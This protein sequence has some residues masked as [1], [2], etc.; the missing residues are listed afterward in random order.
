MFIDSTAA[1]GNKNIQPIFP[2]PFRLPT[3]M[4]QICVKLVLLTSASPDDIDSCIFFLFSSLLFHCFSLGCGAFATAF[5]IFRN[6]PPRAIYSLSPCLPLFCFHFYCV[7]VYVSG[8]DKVNIYF[9]WYIKRRTIYIVFVLEWGMLGS[10]GVFCISSWPILYIE[11]ESKRANIMP[12]P[13][14]HTHSPESF[15]RSG[16]SYHAIHIYFWISSSRFH[17]FYIYNGVFFL[18]LARRYRLC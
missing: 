15:S 16:I 10:A 2:S 3:N 4:E 13:N 5:L 9:A 17:F 6:K 1:M 7:R 8:K 18:S 14:I 11:R 12:V